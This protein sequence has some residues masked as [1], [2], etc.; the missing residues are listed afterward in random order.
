MTVGACRETFPGEARV[1]L[2]PRSADRLKKA[3]FRVVL[4]KDAGLAAGFPDTAFE[5]VG[6]ELLA[7]RSAVFQQADV[8]L[9]V[10]GGGANVEHVDEELRLFRSGQTLIGQFNPLGRP[11]VMQRF[12]EAGV[13]TFALE[14]LPRTTRAQ[15]MDVLSSMASIAG[16]KAVLLG[17]SALPKLMPM[18]MTAAGTIAAAKVFVIGAGVAGLQAIATARRLG[19]VVS[20]YDVR[21]A[22]KEEVQ[23]LGAKFVELDLPTGEESGAGGYARQMNEEFYRRQREMMLSVIAESDLVI[24]TASVPGKKAPLLVTEEMVQAMRPGSVLVDLAAEQGGNCELT[25]PNETVRVHDVTIIGTINL[26]ATVPFHASQMYANNLASFLQH[27]APGGQI[28]IR[29]DDDI[30]RDTMV[31]WDGRLVHHRV[32][33]LLGLASEPD[34]RPAAG[35]S[36]GPEE[37]RSTDPP[38]GPTEEPTNAEPTGDPADGCDGSPTDEPHGEGRS[39]P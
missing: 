13:T 9:F 15:P 32:R 2:T 35:A 27:L 14:L 4:E 23:S 16:Y 28:D 25:R 10:R 12:A 8:V 6:V 29:L 37:K 26:P 22:V 21:P 34:E 3:G 33:E 7:D 30:I 31:T 11:D 39:E 1:A 38:D 36:G 24:T 18:M 5:E 19:A 17:A 20:A